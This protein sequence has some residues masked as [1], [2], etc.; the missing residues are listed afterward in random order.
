MR[1]PEVR[2]GACRLLRSSSVRVS[3]PKL[4]LDSAG[5]EH[6]DVLQELQQRQVGAGAFCMHLNSGGTP[7][8]SCA[9]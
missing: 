3:L 4:G 6:R 8:R 2:W 9:G 5:E 7:D 1:F